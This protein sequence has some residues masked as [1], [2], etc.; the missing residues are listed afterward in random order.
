MTADRQQIDLATFLKK[1]SPIPEEFIDDMFALYNPDT[2]QNDFAIDMESVA[3]WLGARKRVL[4]ETLRSGY[5]AGIDYSVKRIPNPHIPSWS[6]Y[7]RNTYKQVLLTPDCFKRLCMRSKGSVSEHV[8]SYFIETEALVVRYRSQL[9]DG[10][11]RDIDRLE[12][13]QRARRSAKTAEKEKTEGY[14]YVLRASLRYDSVIKLGRTRN[15]IRRLREHSAALADDPEVL[16]IFKTTNA[17]AV[18]TCLKGWLKDRQWTR[19][20]R[21]K[22]VYKADL[23]MVKQLIRGCDLAG[24]VKAVTAHPVKHKMSR[25]GAVDPTQALFIAV[26]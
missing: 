7:G 13:N 19:M 20:A 23:D 2:A 17:P 6:K 10:M 4:M 5:K 14:I 22:E 15:L 9:L 21:Y 12:S 3:K 1:T 18:E 11:Q 25:G 26:I 16:Y 24:K 8:R